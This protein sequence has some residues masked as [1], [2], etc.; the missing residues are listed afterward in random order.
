VR[1]VTP[2]DKTVLSHKADPWL[3]LLTC[4]EYDEQTKSYKWRIAVQAVLVKTETE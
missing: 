4:R 3:T 1:Y 2:T